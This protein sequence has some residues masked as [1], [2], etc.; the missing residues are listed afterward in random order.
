MANGRKK[1]HELYKHTNNTHTNN[2]GYFYAVCANGIICLYF[3]PHDHHNLKL[4][5][6]T[7]FD[8]H[9]PRKYT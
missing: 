6:H 2:K 9:F 1:D 3:L 8:G 7:Y 5:S 4:I